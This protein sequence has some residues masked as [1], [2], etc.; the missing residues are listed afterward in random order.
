MSRTIRKPSVPGTVATGLSAA[1]LL[2]AAGAPGARAAADVNPSISLGTEYSDN[3]GYASANDQAD[4]AATLGFRVP[5]VWRRTRGTTALSF[6]GTYVKQDKEESLDRFNWG[7]AFAVSQTPS[8]RTSLS[9]VAG[10]VHTQAQGDP[11]NLDDTE[12]FLTQRAERDLAQASFDLNRQITKRWNWTFNLNAQDQSS[13]NISDFD[14]G[15]TPSVSEFEDKRSYGVRSGLSRAISGRTS[16]GFQ[17]QYRTFE[18]DESGDQDTVAVNLTLNRTLSEFS[19]FNVS[20]G[21]YRS[22]GEAADGTGAEDESDG[23][24]VAVGYTRSMRNVA[25]NLGLSHAPSS[26]GNLEGTAKQTTASFGISNRQAVRWDWN[27]GLQHGLREPAD[28]AQPDRESTALNADFERAFGRQL[29]LNLG[30]SF[31]H[32]T[33]DDPAFEDRDVFRA[34]AGLVWYPRGRQAKQSGTSP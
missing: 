12:I 9:F 28:P 33:I 29:G 27:V 11:R 7:A 21:G 24:Q 14:G 3:V 25:L 26:G 31:V 18:L 32:Q 13:E 19:S 17:G 23:F 1:L 34:T 20:A 6:N 4:W 15:T 5:I 2:A 10:F 22:T 30:T 16:I 8:P